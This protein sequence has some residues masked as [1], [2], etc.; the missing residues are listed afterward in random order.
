MNGVIFVTGSRYAQQ[1]GALVRLT[2]SQ[3]FGEGDTLYVGD[4]RGV[5][6]IAKEWAEENDVPYRVFYADWEQYGR[7]A[8]PIRNREMLDAASDGSLLLAFP[9]DNSN[10]T[11]DCV[12][13]ARQRGIPVTVVHL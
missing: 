3:N 13:A 5:D 12:T 1:P 7:K 6:A 4:A 10:G 11:W 2:L 8:G 9:H